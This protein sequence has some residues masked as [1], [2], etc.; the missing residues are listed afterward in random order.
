M[1]TALVGSAVA[2]S[3]APVYKIIMSSAGKLSAR[4]LKFIRAHQLY[5]TSRR[6]KTDNNKII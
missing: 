1:L 2:Y 5:Q 6:I 3:H 4:E